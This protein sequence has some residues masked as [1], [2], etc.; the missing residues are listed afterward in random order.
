MQ[1]MR[2]AMLLN[3][4]DH[5]PAAAAVPSGNTELISGSRASLSRLAQVVAK[6]ADLSN[7]QHADVLAWVL[8][9]VA[10]AEV[11]HREL[12]G[13][14]DGATPALRI[15]STDDLEDD[16][17]DVTLADVAIL[18]ASA[19]KRGAGS[20][21]AGARG[22]RAP[23]RDAMLSLGTIA[24]VR[25]HLRRHVGPSASTSRAAKAAAAV[26][27]LCAAFTAT[28]ASDSALLSILMLEAAQA[29]GADGYALATAA[30]NCAVRHFRTHVSPLSTSKFGRGGS[31]GTGRNSIV[32]LALTA[33]DA[34]VVSA[35]GDADGHVVHLVSLALAP[36]AHRPQ[37][38]QAAKALSVA[39]QAGAIASCAN[40]V[41]RAVGSKPRRVNAALRRVLH[42]MCTELHS[43]LKKALRREMAAISGRD[44]SDAVRARVGA[45]LL[46]C[47]ASH[48]DTAS[49]HLD[50][51][52]LSGDE[53]AE[54]T[55]AIAETIGTRC[56]AACG[57]GA[58]SRSR[59]KLRL[60]EGGSATADDGSGVGGD[61]SAGF[62]RALSAFGALARGALGRLVDSDA[63]ADAQLARRVASALDAACG[64]A[65]PPDAST[66]LGV[67]QG[68]AVVGA[69]SN[70]D[71]HAAA[72]A[73][74]DEALQRL[75]SSGVS[76]AGE[77]PDCDIFAFEWP[78]NFGMNSGGGHCVV[79]GGDFGGVS[80]D[81]PDDEAMLE[82]SD[83]DDT[84]DSED[85]DDAEGFFVK[86][87][88]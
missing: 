29:G 62:D 27:P 53:L 40:S 18:C 86:N 15:E 43:A 11:G 6:Q 48:L 80:L 26:L 23:M 67:Q 65:D 39:W 68:N 42:P 24:L 72:Q 34:R 25:A 2:A 35:L 74:C 19:L 57:G 30:A 66:D 81:D 84:E 88:A 21:Q 8:Q 59:K 46:L 87:H 41:A 9:S 10:A 31:L 64:T 3:G 14:C 85:S 36:T 75:L 5:R 63:I 47:A 73:E 37:S 61:A 69:H 54:W 45:G 20:T 70:G 79:S 83:D 4:G 13:A 71:A 52:D 7:D 49:T 60:D 76:D 33:L 17:S 22:V 55:A 58:M 1:L 12:A 16:E 56:K 78:L 51:L 82:P 28:S 77:R 32:D 44:G 50:E 38:H